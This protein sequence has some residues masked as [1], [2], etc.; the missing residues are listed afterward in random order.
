MRFW[1]L[2]VTVDTGFVGN[3]VGPESW[4]TSQTSSFFENF[5]DLKYFEMIFV[6]D[7]T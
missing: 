7:L 3:L 5:V 2:D 4:F 1:E 6:E